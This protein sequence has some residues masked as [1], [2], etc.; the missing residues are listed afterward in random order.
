MKTLIRR[1]AVIF[2]GVLLFVIVI[3]GLR[4]FHLKNQAGSTSTKVDDVYVSDYR[5]TKIYG[6]GTPEQAR[7]LKW[8]KYQ[9]QSDDVPSGLYLFKNGVDGNLEGFSLD[10][11]YGLNAARRNLTSIPT[12]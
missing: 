11:E 2:T 3:I 10:P 8:L 6:P 7:V 12:Q 4:Y 9:Y 1:R 5:R